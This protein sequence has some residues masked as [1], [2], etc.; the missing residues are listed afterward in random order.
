MGLLLRIVWG[1]L[2]LFLERRRLLL[3]VSVKEERTREREREKERKRE[4]EKERKREREKERKRER[5]RVLPEGSEFGS[6]IA[7][8]LGNPEPLPRGKEIL[9]PG[10]RKGE[11]KRERKREKEQRKKEKE[12]GRKPSSSFKLKEGKGRMFLLFGGC[13]CLLLFW[14]L[15][16]EFFLEFL[17]FSFFH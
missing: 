15:S 5:E 7:D 1:I 2:S 6:L 4:R 12:K 3:Q 17:L 13:L 10:E 16:F 11:R 14:W 9:A 8:R